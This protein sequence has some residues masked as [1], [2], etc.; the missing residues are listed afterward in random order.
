MQ[1][2]VQYLNI[3]KNNNFYIIYNNKKIY[4]RK[5][6]TLEQAKIEAFYILDNLCKDTIFI[7]EE[8]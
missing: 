3:Y 1:Y 7:L 2:N 6:K 5:S 8:A 4:L